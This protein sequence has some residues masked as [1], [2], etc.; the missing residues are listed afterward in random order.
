[1]LS[2]GWKGSV[3]MVGDVKLIEGDVAECTRAIIKNSN[4]STVS[5]SD[6]Q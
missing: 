6:G 4:Q 1:V 5:S 3:G 2:L